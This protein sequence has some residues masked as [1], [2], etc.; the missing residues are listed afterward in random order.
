MHI[1]IFAERFVGRYGA[2]RVLV[3]VA[4]MLRRAGHRVTLVGVR[5]SR[6]V[7]EAFPQATVRVPAFAGKHAE[8]MSLGWF[9]DSRYYLRRRLPDFDACLVG[10]FPFVTA[11]PYLRTLSPKV[12]FLDFGVVPTFGYPP[13]LARL[14]DEVRQNR[15]LHL[16]HATDVVAISSFIAED[17]SIKDSRG[18]VP[19]ATILLGAEH[20]ATGLG[21]TEPDGP[22]PEK[23]LTMTVVDRLRRQGRKLILLLGRW[24]PGSYKNSQVAFAVMRSLAD[25]EPDAALLVMCLPQYF[26]VEPG[27]EDSAFC[28]GLPS[29]ADLLEVTRSI[30][31][32]VSVSLWEGF[33]LPI[34]ELQYLEKEVFAFRVAAHPEVVVSSDQLCSDAEEMAGKLFDSLRAGGAPPWVRSGT[35][36]GWREHFSWPRF[37]ADFSRVVERAA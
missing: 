2:D 23:S 16:R 5:F 18:E 6:P 37:M 25:Y 27:L 3:I 15:Q 22:Q 1:G 31:A 10:G 30:A 9:R 19:V 12:I 13:A 21:Y 11:I 14:I 29:D 24:E 28:I 35:V 26:A 7:L 32:G 20:L 4:E 33:N 17:Q 34:A 8:A 36:A